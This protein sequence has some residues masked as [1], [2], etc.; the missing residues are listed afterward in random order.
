MSGVQTCALPILIFPVAVKRSFA[1]PRTSTL[2]STHTFVPATSISYVLMLL[3]R[4]EERR[5]GNEWSSDVCSSDLD[6]P[7]GCEA[8]LRPSANVH[9][10]INPHFCP[11]HI[12]FVRLDAARQIGRASCRE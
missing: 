5:V 4:S 6:L 12:D 8:Q 7:G 2:V 1:P 10:G 9:V 3:A 11:C